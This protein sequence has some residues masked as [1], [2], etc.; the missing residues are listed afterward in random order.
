MTSAGTACSW[1]STKTCAKSWASD[2]WPPLPI[3]GQPI[4]K[5]KSKWDVHLPEGRKLAWIV[6]V[7]PRPLIAAPSH[8]ILPVGQPCQETADSF[9]HCRPAPRA[10]IT[11]GILSGPAPDGLICVEVRAVAR[12]VSQPQAQV[13]RPQ[14]FPQNLPA[15]R[16]RIVPY[17]GQPPAVPPPPGP[18]T[19]LQ[20]PP[21]SPHPPGAGV[22]W[23]V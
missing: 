8:L 4:P 16:Q 14:V 11:G 9:L 2:A 23:D 15:V 20:R 18:R 21:A 19:L 6:S 7:T 13:R 10:Q 17:H 22:S 12:Q 5:P 1:A 3:A